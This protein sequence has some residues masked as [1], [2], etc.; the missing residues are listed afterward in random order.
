[1][2]CRAIGVGRGNGIWSEG[3]GRHELLCL[4]IERIH[5]ICINRGLSIEKSC[6]DIIT[7]WR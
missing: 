2:R 3:C 4:K 7:I 5:Q 1:M 6:T